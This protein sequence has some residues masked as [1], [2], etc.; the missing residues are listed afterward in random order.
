[1][2]ETVHLGVIRYLLIVITKFVPKPAEFCQSLRRQSSFLS[3]SRCLHCRFIFR[4]Q[5]PSRNSNYLLI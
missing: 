1:M 3:L 4:S 2:S 5:L